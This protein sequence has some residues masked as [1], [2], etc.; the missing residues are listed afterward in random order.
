MMGTVKYIMP[1]PFIKELRDLARKGLKEDKIRIAQAVS[2]ALTARQA[3]RRQR[4]RLMPRPKK[5][6]SGDW[7][8]KRVNL[9]QAREKAAERKNESPKLVNLQ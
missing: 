1:F 8:P 3:R 4:A 5:A 6:R 9:E 7:P 2:E